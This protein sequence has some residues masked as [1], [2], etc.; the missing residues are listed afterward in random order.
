MLRPLEA[1]NLILLHSSADHDEPKALALEVLPQLP[2][3]ADH[4]PRF[5]IWTERE[6]GEVPLERIVICPYVHPP[7][8]TP[9]CL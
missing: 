8:P 7:Y 5:Q 2:A 4:V 6:T 3:T 1:K 9:N